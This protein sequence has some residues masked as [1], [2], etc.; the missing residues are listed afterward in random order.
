MINVAIKK[1]IINII[2]ISI[3]ITPIASADTAIVA[4]YPPSNITG[5]SGSEN[6]TM[7]MTSNMTAGTN[8]LD[9][10]TMNMTANMTMNLTSNMTQNMTQNMTAV[11]L[12]SYL[13]RNGSF[14]MTGN[15]TMGLNYITNLL[16][17]SS[18]SSV[19]NKSY[20]D[21]K[22]PS[23]QYAYITLMVGSAM[24][25]TTNPAN[26]DQNETTTNKNNYIYGDFTAGGSEN[27]QWIVDMPA[28]WNISDTTNGKISANFSWVPTTGTGTVNWT[29]SGIA[30]PDN[31]AIDTTLPLI[32][33]S[34]DTVQTVNY[35][36][37]S[38]PT[39][40]AVITSAGTGGNTVIFKAARS[41]DTLAATARLLEV[42]IKYIKTVSG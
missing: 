34:V 10:M 8:G 20:T 27:L 26:M 37:V 1:L 14:P 12:I 16:S 38:P 7:N 5:G 19:V 32:G 13:A 21:T 2:I 41:T 24:I 11:D 28:D 4:P 42:K 35:M 23:T 40:A 15:L 39:T 36:H 33:Y 31:T 9:N 18:G 25:P 22:A 6:M 29:L 30:F 17:G 3:F